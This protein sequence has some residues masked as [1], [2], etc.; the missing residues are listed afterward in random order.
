MKITYT[1]YFCSECGEHYKAMLLRDRPLGTKVEWSLNFDP[2]R[3]HLLCGSW[4]GQDN[5]IEQ[6]LRLGRDC[7]QPAT[8]V[9][10]A[11]GGNPLS[12][13]PAINLNWTASKE[14]S[15]EYPDY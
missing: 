12:F 10:R 14:S 13:S 6:G 15:N 4:S 11:T 3:Q 9:M 1:H 5:N 8:V 2:Q 7:Y